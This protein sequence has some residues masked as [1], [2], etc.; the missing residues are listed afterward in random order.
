MID[1]LVELHVVIKGLNVE[2]END[3]NLHPQA[4]P[5]HACQLP[6]YLQ[7]LSRI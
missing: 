4:V 5:A 6:P 7:N 3:E 2:Y 1:F